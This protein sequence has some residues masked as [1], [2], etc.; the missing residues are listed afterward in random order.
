MI[1]TFTKAT[2]ISAGWDAASEYGYTMW[3]LFERQLKYIK[4]IRGMGEGEIRILPQAQLLMVDTLNVVKINIVRKMSEPEPAATVLDYVLE[5]GTCNY[6]KVLTAKS[7]NAEPLVAVQS[8]EMTRLSYRYWLSPTQSCMMLMYDDACN[9]D[10][11]LSRALA[12]A[13]YV[14]TASRCP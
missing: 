5:F 14:F 3:G 10:N 12:D 8:V 9:L 4:W 6:D 2:F 7:K 13:V 1:I 11:L